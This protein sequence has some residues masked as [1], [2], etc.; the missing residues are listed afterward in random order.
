M[1]FPHRRGDFPKGCLAL[2]ETLLS[3][4]GCQRLF[5]HVDCADALSEG[6]GFNG[7]T[8]Q[9]GSGI[10]NRCFRLDVDAPGPSIAAVDFPR[11]LLIAC[12]VERLGVQ[13]LV[14]K[15]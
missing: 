3:T 1:R 14:E 10:C 15:L 4:D 12:V 7:S 2:L 8:W 13:L 11:L 9:S 5:W 6:S